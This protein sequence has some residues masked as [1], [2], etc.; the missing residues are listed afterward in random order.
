MLLIRGLYTLIRNKEMMHKLYK[1][2]IK[3][4]ELVYVFVMTSAL[5]IFIVLM[6]W[7]LTQ[8]FTVGCSSSREVV[9]PLPVMP[10]QEWC[11][12]ALQC[13]QNIVDRFNLPPEK[14][15]VPS[16]QILSQKGELLVSACTPDGFF[17]AMNVQIKTLT[18]GKC[19]EADL[20]LFGSMKYDEKN[21]MCHIKIDKIME[22]SITDC[23]Y[24]AT[25]N[26]GEKQG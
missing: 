10:T 21:K 23:G 20:V 14:S 26:Q 2:F 18:D 9:K 19:E 3:V 6:L 5:L 11:N 1:W 7:I 15:P 17:T 25:N 4:L 22:R 8:A 12:E 24:G 16:E 13:A